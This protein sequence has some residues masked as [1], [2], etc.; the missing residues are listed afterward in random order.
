M[1]KHGIWPITFAEA[2]TSVFGWLF[3]VD[4]GF[5]RVFIRSDLCFAVCDQSNLGT[6]I[7]DI[8]DLAVSRGLLVAK[9]GGCNF[10]F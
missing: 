2:E 1:F 3:T 10:I 7:N 5:N 9:G 6:T 8:L 4:K